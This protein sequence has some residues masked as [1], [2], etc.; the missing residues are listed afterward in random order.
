MVDTINYA[1]KE[2][3]GSLD[4]FELIPSP[5]NF[6]NIN[7]QVISDTHWESI[8]G[9]KIEDLVLGERNNEVKDNLFTVSLKYVFEYLVKNHRD[10]MLDLSVFF[11]QSG[12]GEIQQQRV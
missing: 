6:E 7:T 1:L 12:I 9:R 2:I 10:F 4:F 8:T 3:E 11:R 5:S